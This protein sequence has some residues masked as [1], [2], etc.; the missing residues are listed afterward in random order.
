MRFFKFINII[1]SDG[2]LSWAT[3]ITIIITAKIALT[4][5]LGTD[6]VAIFVLAILSYGYTRFLAH[7]ETIKRIE[8]DAD[9]SSVPNEIIRLFAR[10]EE[11]SGKISALNLAMG[12]T[13]NR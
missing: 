9:A 3:I 13:K 11:L 12:L 10:V 5:S 2:R 4:Q 7:K 1:D 8:L 6:D